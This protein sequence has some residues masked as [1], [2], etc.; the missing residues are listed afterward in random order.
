MK[1]EMGRAP[2]SFHPYV[3]EESH[4]RGGKERWVHHILYFISVACQE[5]P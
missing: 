2:E 4:R 1:H 5:I 3:T